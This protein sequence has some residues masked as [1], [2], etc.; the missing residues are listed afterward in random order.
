V[1]TVEKSSE[2]LK[3]LELPEGLQMARECFNRSSF[4]YG[5]HLSDHPLF[6]LPPL[7]RLSRR[8]AKP[9]LY[10]DWG[11]VQIGQRWS[12]IPNCDQ[13]LE[14]LLERI[15]NAG[16]W[17]VLR[18]VQ[19][20]DPYKEVLNKLLGEYLSFVDERLHRHIRIREGIV[21][22]TSPNRIST[23]HIDREC[24]LLLQI[25]GEKT[26][27]VFDHYDRKVL[28]ETEIERFW[29][30]DNNAATYKEQL[31]DRAKVYELKPG[32][33]IHIPTNAPH[34]VKNHDNV[35]ISLNVN[36]QFDDKVLANIYRANY[37]LRK[38]G[39]APLP[40]GQSKLRDSVKAASMSCYRGIKGGLKAAS[41]MLGGRGQA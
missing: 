14:N 30:V 5:H 12:E 23:Y 7:L 21:F 17:V 1:L 39:I 15:E 11:N 29:A 22:V 28:P 26:I 16:A 34:W 20:Y 18:N 25:R 9:D 24:S 2:A 31:Q 37:Y 13:P 35:S 36:L 27:S 3:L 33:G 10:F 40:P 8:V 32:M 38:L 19:K 6:E 4:D 41:N